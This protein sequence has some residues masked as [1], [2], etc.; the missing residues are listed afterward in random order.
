M[1]TLSTTQTNTFASTGTIEFVTVQTAG[2]YDITA[3]GAQG[4]GGHFGLG[5]TEAGGLGAMASGEIYLAAGATL[6]IVVG[7]EGGS[8][9]SGGGGGGGGSFV[10]ETNSG[11]GAVDINE[12]IAGGGGGGIGA[13]DDVGGGGR[14]Q[15]TGGN[16]GATYGG[17]GGKAG[18]AGQG[19]AALPAAR[20]VQPAISQRPEAFQ[21]T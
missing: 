15:P 18:A 1:T 7:G 12:V 13:S 9:R 10:I 8:S 5:D 20:A 3:D 16:G 21:A 2:Y 19:G 4:G 14:T 6:E 11:S 17:G